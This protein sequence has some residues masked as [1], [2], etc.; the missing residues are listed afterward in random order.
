MKHSGLQLHHWVRCLSSRHI[1]QGQDL[2][3]ITSHWQTVISYSD[4]E[5]KNKQRVPSPRE[6]CCICQKDNMETKG[7]RWLQQG[8]GTILYQFLP[9]SHP[10]T[11]VPT[12]A[13][14]PRLRWTQPH[15]LPAWPVQTH[16]RFPGHCGK[17]L[18]PLLFQSGP[19]RP[20][21]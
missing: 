18:F 3:N 12:Q 17:A 14:L 19:R 16:A 6:L 9:G 20:I 5:K 1:R 2:S 15:T 11:V 8:C 4:S 7:A 13:V 21:V 10:W